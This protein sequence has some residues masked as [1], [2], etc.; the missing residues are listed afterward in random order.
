MSIF[1]SFSYHEHGCT[2]STQGHSLISRLRN[3]G[4]AT[5]A[6]LTCDTALAFPPAPYYTLYGMVRDQVGQTVTADGAEVILLKGGVEVGR[7][8][9]TL[10]QIDSNYQLF[11]RLDQARSGTTFYT[12]KAVPAGGLF[13]LVVAMNGELFYPI[14]ETRL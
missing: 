6:L 2:A 7:T 11:M 10:S 13:S 12:D 4:L 14:E 9:I 8:P 3:L 1:R 5:L